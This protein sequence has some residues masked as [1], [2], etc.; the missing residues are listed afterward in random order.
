[1]GKFVKKDGPF[2]IFQCRGC[3]SQME[4]SK[5]EKLCVF[6]ERMYEEG[7]AMGRQEAL[8]ESGWQPIETA[9][10]GKPVLGEDGPTI[11]L[12]WSDYKSVSMGSYSRGAGGM[13]P[14]WRDGYGS[15]MGAT[16]THWKPLPEPP[17]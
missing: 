4:P 1:M 5:P 6:C 13:G 15:P 11:L 3:G 12:G 14:T 8:G 10:K 2:R 9:P 16:P 17:E 7:R